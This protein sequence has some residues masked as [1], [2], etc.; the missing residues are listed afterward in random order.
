MRSPNRQLEERWNSQV[1]VLWNDRFLDAVILRFLP[2]SVRP[3]H[4]TV[5]R[6]LLIPPVLISLSFGNYAVGVP[7]FLFAALTDALDGSLARVRRQITEWGVIYDPV[8]DKLLIGSILFF[9]VFRHVDLW[10]GV[11]LLGAETAIIIISWYRAS[12]GRIEPANFWG[13]IKMVF[14]VVGLLLLLIALWLRLNI[15]A[16]V[17]F[18]TLVLALIFAIVTVFT[19]L[20]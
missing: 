4:L 17:S 10:L 11:G 15:L 7:L 20:K 1:R 18:R 2:P 12:H 3:N 14:E 9:I 8:V 13:K 6:F 5:L 16:E 19:R